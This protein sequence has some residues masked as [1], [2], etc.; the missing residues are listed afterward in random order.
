MNS[1]IDFGDL[2]IKRL[3]SKKIA[4]FGSPYTGFVV[5]PLGR[6]WDRGCDRLLIL[7]FHAQRFFNRMHDGRITGAGRGENRASTRPSFA[8]QKLLEIPR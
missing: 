3:K 5:P 7:A 2:R 1:I 8:E 4:A 6:D